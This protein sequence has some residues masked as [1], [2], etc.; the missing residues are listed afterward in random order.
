MRKI[1]ILLLLFLCNST[2]YCQTIIGV[3]TDKEGLE[4][5]GVNIILEN[6]NG[7]ATDIFGKYTAT[8]VG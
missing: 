8:G 1:Y 5:I 2:I 7:T 3:V 4:L 6:G